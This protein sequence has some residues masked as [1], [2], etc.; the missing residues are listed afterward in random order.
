MNKD[1]IRCVACGV[2]IAYADMD[3]GKAQFDFTPDS[4]FTLERSEWLCPACVNKQTGRE[5]RNDGQQ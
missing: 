1:P 4:F 2:F 5:V 3:S